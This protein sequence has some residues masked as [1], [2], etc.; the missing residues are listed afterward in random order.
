MLSR[1]INFTSTAVFVLGLSLPTLA[2]AERETHGPQELSRVNS[3]QIIGFLISNAAVKPHDG[4]TN[5]QLEKTVAELFT[6][7]IAGDTI[8]GKIRRIS[9]N[10]RFIGQEGTDRDETCFVSVRDPDGVAA[11]SVFHFVY[12]AMVRQAFNVVYWEQ[13]AN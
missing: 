9:A 11:T 6:A 7:A 8:D 13:A 12:S 1:F 10:C 5:A 4:I 2:L 3:S